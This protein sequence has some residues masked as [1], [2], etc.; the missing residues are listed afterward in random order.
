MYGL[1]SASVNDLTIFVFE[2]P[3]QTLPYASNLLEINMRYTSAVVLSTLAAGQAAAHSLRHASFH[4]RRQAEA[5]RAPVDYSNPDL[6]KD[7]KWND[8]NWAEALKGVDF[9]K[10]GKTDN[11][12][13]VVAA[14]V[15]SS[16]V[17][18]PKPTTTTTPA[19]TPAVVAPTKTEEKPKET[20]EIT[21]GGLFSSIGDYLDDLED[22]ISDWCAKNKIAGAG[23]NSKSSDAKIWLGASDYSFN[24]CNDG[25]EDAKLVCW[26]DA[27]QGSGSFV[28]S[29]IPDITINI[30]KGQNQTVSFTPGVG[31]ACAPVFGSDRVIGDWGQVYNTWLEMTAGSYATFDVSRQPRMDGAT[32]EAVG[33]K[34]TANMNTCSFTCN[35]GNSCEKGYTLNNCSKA[36]GGGTGKNPYTGDPD[37]GCMMAEGGEIVHV[38]FKN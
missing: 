26:S 7:V 22:G 9:N 10:P 37:G 31:S 15:P 25:S 20:K 3:Y 4:V 36:N 8:I 5:K 30:P 24:F 32:I 1:P 21:L 23:I 34:C 12:P 13:E 28:N 14:A 33:K 19:Y 27:N 38:T 18:A 11:Q 6:Y 2:N 29:V 17:P 35:S 16:S